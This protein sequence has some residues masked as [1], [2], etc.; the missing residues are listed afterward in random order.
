MKKLLT[1]F[2][3]IA[4]FVSCF[5]SLGL[6]GELYEMNYD[7]FP[8]WEIR[9]ASPAE[10]CEAVYDGGDGMY[11]IYTMETG[12]IPYVMVK[13]LKGYD[14]VEDLVNG[15]FME[16]MLE[17]YPDLTVISDLTPVT[18][19]DKDCYE[20]DL[21][22]DIQGYEVLDRRIFDAVGDTIYMF[23]S[24]EV[25]ELEMTLGTVLEDV[26]RES[27][28]LAEPKDQPQPPADT[29]DSL[30]PRKEDP[31]TEPSGKD[32][33]STG[34]D[35]PSGSEDLLI[36]PIE[37]IHAFLWDYDNDGI[38]EAV[39]IRF[40]DNGDTYHSFNYITITGLTGPAAEVYLDHT[41]EITEAQIVT[42]S[43][44]GSFLMVQTGTDPFGLEGASYALV[45]EN[46]EL[47][48]V[49]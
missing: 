27:E 16:S 2:T 39:E 22:Y 40:T 10:G 31:K 23:G 17:A 36:T 19:G 15:P 21:I 35:N 20:I 25:G 26:V 24:K 30:I 46:G 45:Y 49:D 13:A 9:I 48:I 14:E 7:T 33:A 12:K 38:E 5:A 18:I 43:G 32:S 11:Y 28:Y 34:T 37:D 47:L 41:W 4:V 42:V 3:A 6:A 29:R 44:S 1:L 8:D